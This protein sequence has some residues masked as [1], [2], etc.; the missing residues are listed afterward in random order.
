MTYKSKKL[1]KSIIDSLRDKAPL[2][3][4]KGRVLDVTRPRP[5][6]KD[7]RHSGR[8]YPKLFAPQRVIEDDGVFIDYYWDDWKD[9]RDGMRDIKFLGRWSWEDKKMWLPIVKKRIRKQTDI[10]KERRLI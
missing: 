10:R 9:Y 2:S 6:S 5:N 3:N 1:K 8:K 7:R 4:N